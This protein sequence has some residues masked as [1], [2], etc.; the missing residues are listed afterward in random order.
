MTMFFRRASLFFLLIG[1]LFIARTQTTFAQGIVTGTITGTITD[2]S[3]AV[4]RDAPV[5]ATNIATG[6]KIVG[7][8]DVLA[9]SI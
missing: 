3:G 6:T 2:A 8:T 9:E 1:C 7:K 4:V 5:V